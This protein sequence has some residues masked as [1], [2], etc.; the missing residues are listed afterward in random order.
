M[1]DPFDLN[2]FVVAQAGSY[3]AALAEIAAGHKR[4]HWMWYV[5]PQLAGL[6]SSAMAMRYA[7]RSI[8]EA[9]AY[10]DHAVLG[11]RY[12]ACVAALAALPEAATARGV[13]GDIDAMKLCSS[14]TLFA[15][16]RPSA[17]LDAAIGRWCGAA[18][19]RTL[20]LLG[21]AG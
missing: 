9:R 12:G 5:F 15:A 14:L 1:E 10:L 8:D 11:S 4:S 3:A 20:A 13:F 17:M 7:I 19:A 2:R 21:M 16:A 18:D 6:G